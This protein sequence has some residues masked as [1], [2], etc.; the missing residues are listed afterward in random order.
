MGRQSE[1]SSAHEVRDDVCGRH[2]DEP[3]NECDTEEPET[4]RGV[5]VGPLVEVVEL[6][7]Q[8]L[9]YGGVPLHE[10]REV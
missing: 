8:G 10:K 2:D 7:L 4:R 9:Q 3:D 5:R 6:G 1:W